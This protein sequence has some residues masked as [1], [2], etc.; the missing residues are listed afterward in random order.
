VRPAAEKK[1]PPAVKWDTSV[2]G[3]RSL[4][5]ND[6]GS[7]IPSNGLVG[8]CQCQWPI[9]R[10]LRTAIA[11]LMHN[12]GRC[13]RCWSAPSPWHV[14]WPIYG[15]AAPINTICV[16]LLHQPPHVAER[17]RRP[18]LQCSLTTNFFLLSCSSRAK[19]QLTIVSGSPCSSWNASALW[20]RCWRFHRDWKPHTKGRD[21]T[22]GGLQRPQAPKHLPS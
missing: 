12:R 21:R 16:Q 6:Q 19:R 18:I 7:A 1:V 9:T 11:Y 17:R 10:F 8:A 15:L 5:A 14:T 3:E 20:Y 2:R 13:N 22:A 4:F